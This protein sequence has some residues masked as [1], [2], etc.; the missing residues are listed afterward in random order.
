MCSRASFLKLSFAEA[1][2]RKVQPLR[3]GK[4]HARLTCL[5]MGVI[6]WHLASEKSCKTAGSCSVWVRRNPPT[7]AQSQVPNERPPY[8][9]AQRINP[10]YSKLSSCGCNMA[11]AGHLLFSGTS[12]GSLAQPWAL[13]CVAEMVYLSIWGFNKYEN[14][15][16]HPQTLRL[17]THS[18]N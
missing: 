17:K 11:I 18:V 8:F 7:P 1:L 3:G 13:R 6:L 4:L 15:A 9:L 5:K 12:V 16:G 14:R 2:L 10:H